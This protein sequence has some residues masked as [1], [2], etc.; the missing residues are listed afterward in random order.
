LALEVLVECADVQRLVDLSVAALVVHFE[1]CRKIAAS[2]ANQRS[3]SA[4]VVKPY[5]NHKSREPPLERLSS[6][7]SS[8]AII[9][10]E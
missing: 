2:A 10:R 4:A 9:D 7:G 1:D 5:I 8:C 6:L 3:D